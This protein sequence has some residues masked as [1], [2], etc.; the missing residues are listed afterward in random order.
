MSK[1][2]LCIGINKYGHGADLAGCVPDAEDWTAALVARGFT[3]AGL[4]DKAATRARMIEALKELIA[5]GKAGDSLV[6]QYSGH[7][8]FVPDENGD[9]PDGADEALCPVDVFSN[10]VITD[11]DLHEIYSKRAANVKLVIISDSCH[12]GTVARFAAL[13]LNGNGVV[14]K[15]RFL[16]PA[17]FLGESASRKLTTLVGRSTRWSLPPGR[18]A[19]LLLSGCLDPEYSYDA[20]FNGRANGAFTYT[21]L[22]ALKR[23][24]T[25]ATYDRWYKEIRKAL[26]SA[27]YPQTPNF[28]GSSTMKKWTALG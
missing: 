5:K 2:A 10:G 8:S 20:W 16:P 13:P 4:V 23:L 26:P 24:S 6:F 27:D 3:V 21:A 25:K 22:R 7:G 18:H 1:F 12:S 28:F 14:R 19:G 9:E 11:D 17:A 15:A